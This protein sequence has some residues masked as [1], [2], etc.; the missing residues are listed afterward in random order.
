I[1]NP[2]VFASI[3]GIL[4]TYFSMNGIERGKFLEIRENSGINLLY[5]FQM[6][7]YRWNNDSFYPSHANNLT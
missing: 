3:S 4:S 2:S 5:F 7:G 6:D 1:R